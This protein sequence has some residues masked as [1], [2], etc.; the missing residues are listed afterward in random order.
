MSSSL[1]EMYREIILD[2][3]RSPRG[4]QQL[5]TIDISAGG[6]NPSCGDE[7]EMTVEVDKQNGVLKDVHVDCKG[8]AISVAS[9]SMLAETVR[10][11]KFEDVI[12]LAEAVKKLLKGESVDIPEDNEDLQA[13]AGVRQFPVRIK[14]ALLAWATLV[15]G[16][17]KY[18][19][20]GAKGES[21]KTSTEDGD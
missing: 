20:E 16:I 9:G 10:G 11:K 15:E 12:Q 3:Y 21:E 5:K 2:H 19:Q 6:H 1:D 7:I 14:C 13:L 4:K 17:K 8:C 18:G